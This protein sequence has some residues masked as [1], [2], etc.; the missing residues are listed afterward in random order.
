MNI[1]SQISVVPILLSRRLH[2]TVSAQSKLVGV[3][4]LASQVAHDIRS[5]LAALDVIVKDIC[6]IPE[7]QRILIRNATHRIHDIANNLLTQQ[8]KEY[9]SNSVEIK[10]N[11][12]PELIADLLLSVTSEKRAQ[13]KNLQVNFI[14]YID[15]SAYGGFANISI[16]EFKRVLSNLIN[17]AIESLTIKSNGMV[18]ISLFKKSTHLIISIQDNGCGIPDDILPKIISGEIST[19][20]KNGHGLGLSHA[21]QIAEKLGGQLTIKSRIGEGTTVDIFLLQVSAPKWFC[22]SLKILSKQRIVVL[23]DDESI[24]QV[25][26]KRLIDLRS[27]VNIINFYRPEDM[28]E[29][30]KDYSLKDTLF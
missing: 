11:N 22:L 20:K 30:I 7:D 5:P 25:W 6:Y 24:H 18:K 9:I 26:R 16:S 13:Y 28:I 8:S 12:S 27:D 17:N 4:Q 21:I 19:Q 2:L 23:D 15:E 29:K 14:S 10:L 1:W 3:A